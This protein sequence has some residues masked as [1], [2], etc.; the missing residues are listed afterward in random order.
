[1]ELT[2]VEEK[3]SLSL[4]VRDLIK[5]LNEQIEI[6]DSL[7]LSITIHQG[8]TLRERNSKVSVSISENIKY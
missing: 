4:K 7:G 5:Q 3:E 8:W 1:M 2:K 6:A